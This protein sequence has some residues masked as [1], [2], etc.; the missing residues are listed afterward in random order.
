M[1]LCDDDGLF[2]HCRP[3]HPLHFVH[4][5]MASVNLHIH[6]YRQSH[7]N[8]CLPGATA[9]GTIEKEK[10]DIIFY[11][12]ICGLNSCTHCK[13]EEKAYIYRM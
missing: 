12:Y 11:I 13:Q 4:V 2:D 10:E 6:V 5:Y 8:V 9:E 7:L 3:T 1:K